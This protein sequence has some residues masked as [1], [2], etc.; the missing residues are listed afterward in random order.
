MFIIQGLLNTPSLVLYGS[1]NKLKTCEQF[2]LLDPQ[3]WHEERNWLLSCHFTEWEDL[4]VFTGI[5]RQHS[6]PPRAPMYWLKTPHQILRSP[7]PLPGHKHSIVK[8]RQY[9]YKQSARHLFQT[10]LWW[11]VLFILGGAYKFQTKIIGGHLSKKLNL[12]GVKF[13]GGT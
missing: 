5:F 1:K 8:E 7:P 12:G 4:R 2:A 10:L 3:F 13:K 11:K 9:Y 6:K